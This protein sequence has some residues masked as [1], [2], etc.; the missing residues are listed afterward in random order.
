[1]R[2][3]RR[4]RRKATQDRQQASVRLQAGASFQTGSGEEHE[5]RLMYE[6]IQ[7]AM[8]TTELIV[9]H[10]EDIQPLPADHG[11]R[12]T[13]DDAI[14]NFSD[15]KTL[16]LTPLQI[17]TFEEE[18]T[19]AASS[20]V[21]HHQSSETDTNVAAVPSDDNL[22]DPL[23]DK[24]RGADLVP[25][26]APD[27]SHTSLK[28][29]QSAPGTSHKVPGPSHSVPDVIPD[30]T[31]VVQ[32]RIHE[33]QEQLCE[34]QEPSPT[35]PEPPKT[36]PGLSNMTLGLPRTGPN[37]SHMVPEPSHMDTDL[38]PT[39]LDPPSAATMQGENEKESISV[40]TVVDIPGEVLKDGNEKHPIHRPVHSSS[41]HVTEQEASLTEM[42][43]QSVVEP[44][45]QQ[46]CF[47]AGAT[48]PQ[49]KSGTAS[50]SP[51]KQV[52]EYESE[53]SDMEIESSPYSM[54]HCTIDERPETDLVLEGAKTD[55]PSRNLDISSPVKSPEEGTRVR[56]QTGVDLQEHASDTEGHLA[57]E[58]TDDESGMILSQEAQAE[59]PENIDHRHSNDSQ[60]EVHTSPV[61]CQPEGAAANI[62][63]RSKET[64]DR[65]PERR[66]DEIE[67]CC[68]SSSKDATSTKPTNV[69][70]S[71]A[72]SCRKRKEMMRSGEDMTSKDPQDVSSVEKRAR[73]H[74]VG[75]CNPTSIEEETVTPYS[76]YD[77]TEVTYYEVHEMIDDS[78]E[79]CP[80]GFMSAEVNRDVQSEARAPTPNS[81]VA[82][83]DITN[84]NIPA[85]QRKEIEHEIIEIMDSSQE[86]VHMSSSGHSSANAGSQNK[87]NLDVTPELFSSSGSAKAHESE[88]SVAQEAEQG[89][90]Q[91]LDELR[92]A[93]QPIQH[94]SI[95]LNNPS[96]QLAPGST[97]TRLISQDREE[98]IIISSQS[99]QEDLPSASIQV[100]SPSSSIGEPQVGRSPGVDGEEEFTQIRQAPSSVSEKNHIEAEQDSLI[101][102]RDQGGDTPIIV[103]AY[104]LQ[105][106]TSSSPSSLSQSLLAA[107]QPSSKK[108]STVQINNVQTS[109]TEE[110]EIDVQSKPPRKQFLDDYFVKKS[111]SS[112]KDVGSGE[113]SMLPKI[114]MGQLHIKQLSR[115]EFK[116]NLSKSSHH[117][118]SAVQDKSDVVS[119][120]GVQCIPSM[121]GENGENENEQ[122]NVSPRNEGNAM[123]P[124]L[125]LSQ[126]HLSL[127]RKKEQYKQATNNLNKVSTRGKNLDRSPRS[128][129]VP[130]ATSE[131][132]TS[133][134]ATNSSQERTDS[135]GESRKRDSSDQGLLQDSSHLR[136]ND[137]ASES[138]EDALKKGI[139]TK[140][141]Y[142]RSF[143]DL[144]SQRK[145]NAAL[146]KQAVEQ[147]VIEREEVKESEEVTVDSDEPVNRGES[148][149][150]SLPS[151][152]QSTE[153]PSQ[154]DS[155][156]MGTHLPSGSESSLASDESALVEWCAKYFLS[157]EA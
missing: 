131:K 2:K 45:E 22:P 117:G 78:D 83:G 126:R 100:I 57:V 55:T 118:K 17:D 115:K 73:M 58:S 47:P 142:G 138:G 37:P 14:L 124:K 19:D 77:N 82:C 26:V 156:V 93:C 18:N 125:Y 85:N 75:N 79:S 67:E 137:G 60:G 154:T 30:H 15:I 49:L 103:S 3:S 7:R 50:E 81:D 35:G 89:H 34:V 145:H 70:G 147:E 114:Y 121:S 59:L 112:S 132:F 136:A 150:F 13:D 63:S 40:P 92:H 90:H 129:D 16:E 84:Q 10:P 52:E 20:K 107:Q 104:S 123:Q 116:K 144:E 41:S 122:V 71:G 62:N 11:M 80:S 4:G 152:R 25:A 72:T 101:L 143:K 134:T 1:M 23:H 51:A 120:A 141:M 28:P 32:E 61:M 74:S 153:H 97:C 54:I 29:T 24:E 110:K 64:E 86:E 108:T 21:S 119:D 127:I 95:Y 139:K 106:R 8:P 66:N 157:L 53:Q 96:N 155:M 9:L 36:L 91:P 146:L 12:C 27:L 149:V 46:Q 68:T 48:S 135:G 42:N 44:A 133:I 151:S 87:T 65:L 109:A 98:I 69:A 113:P 105:S 39:A 88:Q 130:H 5:L 128:N 76:M 43:D 148:P 31:C 99:D 111:K 33:V 94:S 140:L 6:R 102:C 56:G 38:F